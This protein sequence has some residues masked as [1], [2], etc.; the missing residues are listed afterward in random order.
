VPLFLNPL[1]VAYQQGNPLAP[2][3]PFTLFGSV[4]GPLAPNGNAGAVVL[5]TAFMVTEPDLRLGGFW[6]WVC[7]TGSQPTSAQN[8]ALW[9][10]TSATTGTL[11]PGSLITSGT[12]TPGEWYCLN[13]VTPLALTQYTPYRAVTGLTGPYP[14][15]G[16]QWNTGGPYAAG[17]TN[18]ALVA[19]S[20]VTG[21]AP[22]PF[23]SYQ[24]T[25]TTAG[26]DPAAFYPATGNSGFNAW[27]DVE[28]IA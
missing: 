5:G 17:I 20:D 27:I 3:P 8:F 14:E 26:S 22:D 21:S 18:G 10:E 15:T 23:G 25:Y 11:V 4:T 1:W 19:Y 28:I 2:V 12:M 7:A 16:S 9:Q 13:Y 24:S 6:W